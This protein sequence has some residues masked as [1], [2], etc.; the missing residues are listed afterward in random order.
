MTSTLK[1]L[2]DNILSAVS[3]LPKPE[4]LKDDERM[5][6]L[7]AL[8]KLRIALEPPTVSIQNLCFGAHTITVVRV[9]QG[10]GIFDAFVAGQGLEMTLSNLHE[11]TRGDE[12]LLRRVVRLLCSSNVIEEVETDRF[13]PTPLAMMFANGLPP[14]DAIKHFYA[15]MPVTARL[16]QY[17]ER[18]GYKN[19]EDA[20][21]SPFQFGLNTND[22]YFEWLKRNP[23][24]QQA[25]NSVMTMGRTYRSEEWYKFYPV[26]QRLQ[27][28]DTEVVLVD[29][30]GGIGHDISEVKAQFPNLPG[31]MI[32]QELP[33]VIDSIQQP[34]A[35]GIETLKHDMF[36][37]QPIKGAKAYYMRTVLHDWPNKQALVAL[38]R[39]REAMTRDSVLLLNEN[40]LPLNNVPKY[41]AHLDFTMMEILGSLER[42]ERQWVDLITES[43][44]K[45]I[46]IWKPS[47]QTFG[48]NLLLEAAL[49]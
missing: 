4:D 29:I 21:N 18:T 13:K 38:T 5:R 22:H 40:A 46:K 27:V 23:E 9:A 15:Q 37:E 36:T 12:L 8:D 43:G 20:Y 39:I 2:T 28:K 33:H 35:S 10:M 6:L 24:D 44:L 48:S 3:S 19:P 32:L 42:T 41:S 1:T 17:F 25:F 11:N 49:T 34:L 16:Y 26:E 30:G 7:D 47:T 45:L 14:G 31:R